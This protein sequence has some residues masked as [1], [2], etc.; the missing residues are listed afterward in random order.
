MIFHSNSSH[1]QPNVLKTISYEVGKR[2]A[3]YRRKQKLSQEDLGNKIGLEPYRVYEYEKG[4]HKIN[5]EALCVFA[6]AL[7][8]PAI[9]L[10]GW[11][12]RGRRMN[13][14]GGDD[15]SSKTRRGE[16]GRRA[17]VRL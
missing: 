12:R 11:C 9:K 10:M 17:K 15:N 5:L 13:N 4:I 2:I 3:Y 8:I 6:S 14:L 16:T 1:S 7:E